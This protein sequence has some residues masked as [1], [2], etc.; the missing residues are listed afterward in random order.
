MDI[1]D[2]T[3]ET[4]SGAK[5][6]LHYRGLKNNTYS[7][8]VRNA[9]WPRNCAISIPKTVGKEK[10]D[11]IVDQVIENES[12]FSPENTLGRPRYYDILSNGVDGVKKSNKIWK[13]REKNPEFKTYKNSKRMWYYKSIGGN[14]NMKAIK[15][16]H[17]RLIDSV[18]F[19]NL[20][21]WIKNEEVKEVL[22]QLS[23]QKFEFEAEFI[24]FC[25]QLIDATED[26]LIVSYNGYM[27][28]LIGT[29]TTL[30][31]HKKDGSESLTYY[32]YVEAD[33]DQATKTLQESAGRKDVPANA[34]VKVVEVNMFPEQVISQAM[35]DKTRHDKLEAIKAY[36]DKKKSEAKAAKKAARIAAKKTKA[37]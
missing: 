13:L 8:F 28:S 25:D 18:S 5:F 14:F 11:A 6:S 2:N 33:A 37:A 3:I 7:G 19:A 27:K 34:N 26:T 4:K 36:F 35:D 24:K 29:H 23:R 16:N 10:F 31:R 9:E 22:L 17:M 15:I 20:M 12:K 1:L 30:M 21:P 32:V